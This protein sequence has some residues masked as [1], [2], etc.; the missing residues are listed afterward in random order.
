MSTSFLITSCGVIFFLLFSIAHTSSSVVQKPG[1][2]QSPLAK[3]RQDE[4][5]KAFSSAFAD[6]MKFGF[7]Y[8]EGI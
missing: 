5:K 4:V 8:D 7:P 6:Y 1:L 3:A 2:V